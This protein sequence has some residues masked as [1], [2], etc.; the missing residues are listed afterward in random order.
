MHDDL[1]GAAL[2]HSVWMTWNV[3]L[4]LVPLLLSRSL[5][6]TERRRGAAWWT[7]LVAF[8]LFLPNAPYV[9]TDVIH[10][11]SDVRQVQSEAVITFVVLPVYAVFFVIGVEAYVLA[12][13]ELSDWLRRRNVDRAHRLSIRLGIHMLCA[14][15]VQLGRVDRLNSWDTVIHPMRLVG[16]S[17]DLLTDPARM[18]VTFVVIAVVFNGMKALTLALRAW[19][20]APRGF[21]SA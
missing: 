19:W 5:F 10:L 4:A 7:G 16:A 21:A 15:G 20:T 8:V 1:V 13:T 14:F 6:H 9:L 17:F 18:L 2:R 11:I 3:V 12:M